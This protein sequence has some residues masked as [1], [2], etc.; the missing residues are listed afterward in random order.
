MKHSPVETAAGSQPQLPSQTM[1]TILSLLLVLHL[2]ALLVA[3]VSNDW[4]SVLTGRLRSVPGVRP[5]LQ[6]LFMD[7]SY[8]YGLTSADRLDVD[9]QLEA[10]MTLE[11]GSKKTVV[12]PE[13]GVWPKERY[14]RYERL[15][16]A[17]AERTADGNDPAGTALIVQSVAAR[18]FS[19]QGAR[20]GRAT[21]HRIRCRG[22]SLQ[23]PGDVQAGDRHQQDPFD[24]RYYWT[25]Y[26]ATAWWLPDGE[27]ELLPTE[28]AG[29]TA[30]PTVNGPRADKTP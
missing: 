18:L 30:P 23:A 8:R 16:H 1:R 21:P 17:I 5:Y 26:E 22:H 6:L 29:D 3:L 25:A 11:D 19:E 9:F 28:G 10:D 4:V 24:P 7:L 14:R 15:V 2:F 13:Q 12:F 20:K 27:V